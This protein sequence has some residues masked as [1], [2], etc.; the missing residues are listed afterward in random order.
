MSRWVTEVAGVDDDFAGQGVA[1]AEAEVEPP[2]AEVTVDHRGLAWGQEFG[3]RQAEPAQ[4]QEVAGGA[5][6]ERTR[7]DAERQPHAEA[8]AGDLQQG[9][10]P[11]QGLAGDD[12][13]RPAT[14]IGEVAPPGDG[15]I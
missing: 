4:A 2:A 5:E 3:D 7:L 11:G 6:D 1:E 12:G 13:E 14:R 15:P 9:A 10:V 8:A